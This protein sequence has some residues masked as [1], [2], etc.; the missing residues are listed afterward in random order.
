MYNYTTVLRTAQVRKSGIR[1]EDGDT[2]PGAAKS[3][4]FRSREGKKRAAVVVFCPQDSVNQKLPKKLTR[5]VM[6][7]TSS[8]IGQT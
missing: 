1:K 3:R 5:P 2:A 7:T 6:T 4:P 8:R